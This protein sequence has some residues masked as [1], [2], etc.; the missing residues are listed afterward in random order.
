MKKIKEILMVMVC[1][2]CV[3]LIIQ[4][5]MKQVNPIIID[6]LDPMVITAGQDFYLYEGKSTMASYG[7]GFEVGD[8]IYIDGQ[9]QDTTVGNSGWITCFVDRK[10]YQDARNLEVQIKRI[11]EKGKVKKAS[12]IITIRV[13]EDK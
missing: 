11:D 6:R 9:P 4:I 12:N 1:I 10:L 5:T 7:K 8:V 2:I 13:N 3:I